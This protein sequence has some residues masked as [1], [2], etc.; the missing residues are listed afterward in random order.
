MTKLDELVSLLKKAPDEI[1][2]QAHNVPDPDAI[3]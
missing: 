1:F 3:A 2:L